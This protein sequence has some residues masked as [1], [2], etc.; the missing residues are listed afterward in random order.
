M[1]IDDISAL[2]RSLEEKEVALN[3][4]LTEQERR[5]LEENELHAVSERERAAELAAKVTLLERQLAQQTEQIAHLLSDQVQQSPMVAVA[6]EAASGL[7]SLS[8]ANRLIALLDLSEILNDCTQEEGTAV[9][10]ALREGGAVRH[11]AILL[12]D[13]NDE[14]SM[15]A[16]LLCLANLCSDS[17]DASSSETKRELLAGDVGEA[18]VRCLRVPPSDGLAASLVLTYAAGLCLN[19]S[20]D[21][22]WSMTLLALGALHD[23][24]ALVNNED[25]LV[26]H[27]AKGTLINLLALFPTIAA[28]DA[29]SP[30]SG[31]LPGAASTVRLSDATAATL[32]ES[33][34]YRSFTAQRQQKLEQQ[35]ALGYGTGV[36]IMQVADPLSTRRRAS[37][38]AILT[39]NGL[40]AVAP[41]TV[42][43]AAAATAAS[44]VPATVTRL[45]QADDPSVTAVAH[46]ADTGQS[47]SKLV[48]TASLA[49]SAVASTTA[50]TAIAAP[51]AAAS[52][53]TTITA[54]SK[55]AAIATAVIPIAESAAFPAAQLAASVPNSVPVPAAA[56]AS[57][58]TSIALTTT[59]VTA[60]L[61]APAALAPA[62]T[63]D[64][65]PAALT[66][67][68]FPAATSV[69]TALATT[70]VASA[71]ATTAVA[72]TALATTAVA[73]TMATSAIAAPL[74]A[75]SKPTTI[76]TTSKPAAVAAAAISIAESAVAEVGVEE[77]PVKLAMEAEAARR[78]ASTDAA[79]HQAEMERKKAED[80]KAAAEAA[81]A[82]AAAA[83][84]AAAEA[85][86]AEK[87]AAEKA[88][89]EKAAA[90][91][92]AAE[93]AAAEKAAVERAAAEAAAAE[94][95]AAEKA[96]AEKAAA[97]KAALTLQCASRCKAARR[98]AA[99]LRAHVE[100]EHKRAAA[101]CRAATRIQKMCR[102]CM[103]RFYYEERR[104]LQQA[105]NKA[106]AAAAEARKNKVAQE[107]Q[108]LARNQAAAEGRA[109]TK[110]QAHHRGKADRARVDAMRLQAAEEAA[111]KHKASTTLQANQRGKVDRK[112]LA[113]E[114]V[115]AE[116]A[117]TD[118]L[119]SIAETVAEQC[120]AEEAAKIAA[121]KKAQARKRLKQIHA[122]ALFG[123]K[124]MQVGRQAA[125]VRRREEEVVNLSVD[126][127]ASL[128]DS[129]IADKAEDDRR[130][131]ARQKRE[132]EVVAFGRA[133]AMFLVAQM[134]KERED[135][136]K[137]Y[138][139]E[140][141]KKLLKRT[142]LDK[143]KEDK[144][145]A[146]IVT[147]S[148]AT[149]RVLLAVCFLYKAREDAMY[150]EARQVN[151]E[152]TEILAAAFTSMEEQVT[153]M[154][155]E[156]HEARL[157]EAIQS[158]AMDLHLSQIYEGADS[159]AYEVAL[160]VAEKQEAEAFSALTKASLVSHMSMLS[161][162]TS[163][164]TAKRLE[165]ELTE[166]LRREEEAVMA[167]A[168]AAV[169]QK[170]GNLMAKTAEEEDE[171]IARQMQQ[172]AARKAEEAS[173]PKPS[174]WDGVPPLG[175]RA[176]WSGLSP[177][178]LREVL[179]HGSGIHGAARERL[180]NQCSAGMASI[181]KASSTRPTSTP[182]HSARISDAPARQFFL[183][184][185]TA[186]PMQ[187]WHTEDMDGDGFGRRR[188]FSPPPSAVA[189][190][191]LPA[192]MPAT[193]LIDREW[194]P[195]PLAPRPPSSA[196]RGA[197]QLAPSPRA[198]QVMPA[199]A[200]LLAP[201]LTP[202]TRPSTRPAT[203]YASARSWD[204]GQ[205]AKHEL[206]MQLGLDA[207]AAEQQAFGG[208]RS[209][210]ADADVP[211][212]RGPQWARRDVEAA[213]QQLELEESSKRPP[214]L[215]ST[216]RRG[217][218]V[219]WAQAGLHVATL[220]GGGESL[221]QGARA[222]DTTT[223]RDSDGG[224]IELD[225]LD[226][227]DQPLIHHR[228]SLKPETSEQ[229]AWADER[230]EIPH[231][232]SLVSGK[233]LEATEAAFTRHL[234]R[235]HAMR[236][237]TALS[238]RMRQQGDGGLADL[239]NVAELPL[240]RRPQLRQSVG[241]TPVMAPLM[242][243]GLHA[244]VADLI[245]LASKV[246]TRA[247]S[248]RRD[249]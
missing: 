23:F 204:E 94:K 19:V 30:S 126:T 200:A 15:Q 11:L 246:R 148:D 128:L 239:S 64:T 99:A 54:T 182:P 214:R 1:L 114:R 154:A 217:R 21:Y 186:T 198:S 82:E 95:V 100:A 67:A 125:E 8:P 3:T 236:P 174:V 209:W 31:L 228:C 86:A 181:A 248:A 62:L 81:A 7:Y 101:E 150:A 24:Q 169:R 139:L 121:E 134:L 243:P 165:A 119:H 10:R 156:E 9:G 98:E 178:A 136:I 127:I 238:S 45:Q 188:A 18:V 105:M 142:F 168:Q 164:E 189:A 32:E 140:T 180:V 68:A 202:S 91:K 113:E 157:S 107:M 40:S 102:G 249:G 103:A 151:Y 57:S 163:I 160:E 161:N 58:V 96:A 33:H 233:E 235:A 206:R 117:L 47:S 28:L 175:G 59:P 137:Q 72:T 112:M 147:Y 197:G 53:P 131:A 176:D 61:T 184:S 185:V 74:A 159:V 187:R 52:E 6:M 116:H 207:R 190:T 34:E 13:F 129:C 191:Y 211:M 73:S 48:Q 25:L 208:P 183:P 69:P 78:A 231:S 133:R 222:E 166:E 14:H 230:C 196:R 85:A 5:S 245:L 27:Y 35:L 124:G 153:Q 12:N 173:R 218:R 229:A 225:A 240:T 241:Q 210:Q 39:A 55:P 226:Q 194:R 215:R 88:A 66:S 221:L 179:R 135:E 171:E 80:E 76:S 92:E 41:T 141:M 70:A 195:R 122:G 49:T 110:L 205:L 213:L 247:A 158:I 203:A 146:E 212:N 227:A 51:L 65:Q 118:A 79:K 167:A 75:A 223:T 93:K 22:P 143:D 46:A 152:S 234:L 216:R 4:V 77:Q 201:G 17:L 145:E 60:V 120:A 132:A 43:A 106:H 63:S 220:N 36:E 237:R 84:A 97:E 108:M 29:S 50:S 71:P 104:A 20:N 144:R 123:V 192:Q 37:Q 26:A 155:V 42:T 224:H 83:K 89:A 232:P 149:S 130:E 219:P 44:I 170:M 90:E 109:A 16:M 115:A 162:R 2:R 138:A 177:R 56:I 193:S 242:P 87:A 111:A 244:D 172:E 38:A 199:L